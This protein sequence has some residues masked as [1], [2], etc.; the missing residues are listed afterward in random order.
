M[1][2]EKAKELLLP[3]DTNRRDLVH[4]KGTAVDFTA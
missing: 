3:T 4:S 2:L 1:D